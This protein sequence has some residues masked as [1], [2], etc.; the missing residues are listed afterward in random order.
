MDSTDA[1]KRFQT[2]SR[3]TRVGYP[4]LYLTS[5]LSGKPG[6]CSPPARLL[7]GSCR[8]ERQGGMWRG[9]MASGSAANVSGTRDLSDGHHAG[10]FESCIAGQPLLKRQTIMRSLREA[11]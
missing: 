11:W 8:P 4:L 5:G 6:M 3:F 1:S 10:S 2:I 7:W 9:G